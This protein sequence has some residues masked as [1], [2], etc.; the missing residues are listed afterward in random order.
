MTPAYASPEQ[1]RGERLGTQTDVYSLGVLLYELLTGQ[2][3]FDL[4]EETPAQA[5]RTVTQGE[6]LPPSV[7]RLSAAADAIPRDQRIGKGAWSDLD[8]LCL[9]AMHKDLQRRYRSV[10]ALIRDIDHYLKGEPLEARP[11]SQR[12]R[13]AKFAQ[14]NRRSLS[15]TVAVSAMFI[16]LVV[17]F[18][19]RLARARNTA[20][21]EAT[22]SQ[23]IERFMLNLFD[24]GD[25]SAGPADSLRAVALLDRG[26]QN[27]RTLNAEPAVQAELYQTLGNMYQKLGRFD[28]AEPLLR[29]SL[30]RRKSLAGQDSHDV[31]DSLVALGLLRLDQGQLPEAERFV[32]EGLAMDRQ[33]LPATDPA[34]GR[35][36]SAMGRVLEERGAPGEAIKILDEAVRLQSAS[37]EATMDLSDSM[38]ALATAQCYVGHLPLAESLFKRALAMDLALFGAIHPRIAD[39]YYDLGAVQHDMGN[40]AEAEQYYRKALAIK[41]SWYGKEHPD[42]AFMT[43]AVG[44]SLIYQRR[45][46][47]AAPLLQE[48][49]AIQ[50]RIFGKV[51]P[52]VAMGLNVLGL[53]E[54]RRGHLTDAEKD[55][56]RMADIDRAVYG[57]KHYDVGLA[58]LNLGEVHLAEKNNTR[59]E[60]EYREALACCFPEN[61]PTGHG[62]P[63]RAIAQARLGHALV[64]ERRYKE[65]E[66][67]LMA[68]YEVLIKEP[69]QQ[70][71]RI[72]D[73]RQD[74]I[75]VYERLN[76][77]DQAKKFEA[78]L[79]ANLAPQTGSPP[80][81]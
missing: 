19:L 40:D 73:A 3:P 26:V 67:H 28:Q 59:A 30:E 4:S 52:Q 57:D 66:S 20:L 32:R 75:T 68:G 13:L 62:G 23:R 79:A 18:V 33:H 70:A 9:T 7:R 76:E 25:K 69:G 39:D 42:S 58:L 21:A 55:F 10:E 74:L 44:Q 78:E 61:L 29:S 24:G 72:H 11:D 2:L 38:S 45:Y 36:M 50:E 56:T 60:S 1:I 31:A 37:H 46:D 41:Q 43:V 14:R 47:E 48:A 15:A 53:L 17:F 65:A 81:H 77:P 12:Y 71:K 49:L 64:L 34:V 8:V 5:E 63:A 80:S 54:I 6:P 27:A 35:A 22:R 16:A 51:H